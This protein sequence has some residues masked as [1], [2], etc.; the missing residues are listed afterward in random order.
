MNF[1]YNTNDYFDNLNKMHGTEV[2]VHSPLLPKS[3]P[4]QHNVCMQYY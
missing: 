2:I 1:I 3:L 4:H